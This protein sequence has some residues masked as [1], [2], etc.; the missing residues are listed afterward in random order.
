MATTFYEEIQ[1]LLLQGLEQTDMFH[2]VTT[3]G[4]QT[5]YPVELVPDLFKMTVNQGR[6]LL[7]VAREIDELRE[8]TGA[9]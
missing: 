5:A 4:R 8:A 6:A 3:Q 9:A 1:A 2:Q 7:K